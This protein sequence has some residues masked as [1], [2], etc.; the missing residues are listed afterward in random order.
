[1]INILIRLHK[2][3]DKFCKTL[4]SINKQTYKNINI[5]VSVDVLSVYKFVSS[6]NDTQCNFI[7]INRKK[8]DPGEKTVEIDPNC[9]NKNPRILRKLFIPN[10]YFNIL[11]QHIKPGYIFYLDVG[12][13]ILDDNMFTDL[14]PHMSQKNTIIW[15]VLAKRN[16]II[17]KKWN[18]YPVVCH[19]DSSNFM[20]HSDYI[21]NWTGYRGGDFRVIN[22]IYQKNKT[23]FIPKT[24]VEKDIGLKY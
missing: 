18:G 11:H 2:N 13:S 22:K 23:I 7:Y 17:P 24:Y 10:I 19:I 5:L 21:E 4:E 12:D 9:K 8:L 14:L 20:F 3:I 16:R 15:R 1:M 6:K